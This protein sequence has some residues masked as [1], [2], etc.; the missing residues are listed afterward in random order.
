MLHPSYS[1]LIQVVNDGAEE[2]DLLVQSRY[3]I[4]LATAK[5]ARQI[6]SS[7]KLL[8]K[9]KKALSIAIDE[10]YNQKVKITIGGEED[11]SSKVKEIDLNEGDNDLESKDPAESDVNA[12]TFNDIDA[13]EDTD[14]EATED[15]D[16][17]ASGEDLS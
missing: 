7:N 17:N 4:V 13:V 8:A 3:S 12:E 10:I 1:D 2:G 15:I 11:K 16:A 14:A 9:K 5:R 6:I